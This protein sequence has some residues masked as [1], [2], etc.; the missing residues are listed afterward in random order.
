MQIA[1]LVGA[2]RNYS[3]NG[4]KTEVGRILEDEWAMYKTSK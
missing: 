1:F 4:L 3:E 2:R